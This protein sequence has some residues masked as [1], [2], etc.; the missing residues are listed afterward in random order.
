M[1]IFLQQKMRSV[2]FAEEKQRRQ[3]LEKEAM[4][5]QITFEEIY[6]DSF[7]NDDGMLFF[8]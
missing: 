1:L 4:F 7:I 2:F 8:F 5:N 6:D 3:C